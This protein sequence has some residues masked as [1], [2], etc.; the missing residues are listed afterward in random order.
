MIFD[1][2]PHEKG[3]WRLDGGEP[4]VVFYEKPQPQEGLL[5]GLGPLY[6]DHHSS[7][8][9]AAEWSGKGRRR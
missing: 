4:P 1:A 5:E 8:P 6:L 7:C 9:S 2:E 3:R